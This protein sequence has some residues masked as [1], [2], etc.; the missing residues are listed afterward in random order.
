MDAYTPDPMI[1]RVLA[2]SAAQAE[3]Q[4][5]AR[6]EAARATAPVRAE[7][8]EQ[9]LAAAEYRLALARRAHER[10][11][12]ELDDALAAAIPLRRAHGIA[13]RA[14]Y[15]ATHL[16]LTPEEKAAKAEENP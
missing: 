12:R 14:A 6:D 13:Q 1:Q 2:E 5:Q 9:R 15:R 16:L 7:R 8:E 3:A 11:R 4:V 10:T